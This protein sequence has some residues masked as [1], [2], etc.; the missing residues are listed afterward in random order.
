MVFNRNITVATVPSKFGS[1]WILRKVDD[2]ASDRVHLSFHS[3]DFTHGISSLAA[4]HRHLTLQ[5]CS[6]VDARIPAPLSRE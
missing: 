3:D 6:T 1:S 4:D 2:P 5:W